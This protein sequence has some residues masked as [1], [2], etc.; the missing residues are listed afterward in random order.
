MCSWFEQ[1]LRRQALSRGSPTPRVQPSSSSSSSPG[2]SRRLRRS[3]SA[4]SA[5][6][7]ISCSPLPHGVES[8]Y[9][10]DRDREQL[11]R[12]VIIADRSPF[13]AV[14]YGNCGHLLEPIIRE[15]IKEIR[16]QAG[17]EV[18]TV[19]VDVPEDLLWQRIQERLQREPER[20]RLNEHKMDWMRHTQEW[21]KGFHWDL[22]VDNGRRC[23]HDV[24]IEVLASLKRVVSARDEDDSSSTTEEGKDRDSSS[25]ALTTAASTTTTTTS[26]TSTS[27]ASSSLPALVESSSPRLPS[28][29]SLLNRA[30][31][32]SSSSSSS[33]RARVANRRRVRASSE[34]A[35][36]AS[37]SDCGSDNEWGRVRGSGS[38]VEDDCFTV[39]KGERLVA[40]AKGGLGLRLAEVHG[41]GREGSE[42]I[43]SPLVFRGSFDWDKQA[44]E[45]EG[46]RGGG[47]VVEDKLRLRP[48]P[49]PIS[50]SS[51]SSS[52]SAR[53]GETTPSGKTIPPIAWDRVTPR[54]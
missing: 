15:Q 46:G 30:S 4:S 24:M 43:L 42:G 3:S 6:E 35:M 50:S 33:R 10:D 19:H 51:S 54:P 21:Y 9:D 1:L 7:A 2:S 37:Y 44:E 14:F 40:G 36:S 18:V 49:R 16:D 8:T 41:A 27:S 5:A 23:V 28:A 47:G 39:R 20:K 12:Q 13:S 31:S 45:E 32:S 52:G 25:T 34:T 22:T 11:R 53:S 38:S 17:I 26:S 48:P 29:T